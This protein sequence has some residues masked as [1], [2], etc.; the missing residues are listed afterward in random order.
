VSTNTTTGTRQATFDD[1]L[2]QKKLAYIR[3]RKPVIIGFGISNHDN[4]QKAC[5]LANGAIIGSA[6]INALG[7]GDSNIRET[8]EQFIQSIRKSSYD[9]TI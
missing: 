4:F 9:H 8:T 1:P 3:S 5:K 7:K 2:T 6:Y